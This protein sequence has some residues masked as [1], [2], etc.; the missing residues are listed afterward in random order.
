MGQGDVESRIVTCCTR[1]ASG[2]S[3]CLGNCIINLWRIFWCWP[4]AVFRE[5]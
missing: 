1:A 5:M 4:E 2:F 3:Q